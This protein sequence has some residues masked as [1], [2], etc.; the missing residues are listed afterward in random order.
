MTSDKVDFLMSQENGA[1]YIVLYQML[2]LM[3]I[4]TNGELARA[5]NEMLIPYD[6]EKIKRDC[7]YFSTDTIR[8]ALELY[9]KLGMIYV[10]ENGILK[11]ENFSNMVG[12]ETLGAIEKREQRALTN[13][14]I[15]KTIDKRIDNVYQDNKRLDIRDIETRYKRLDN[16]EKKE[17]ELNEEEEK[18]DF[19]REY[20]RSLL[21]EIKNKLPEME[22][23]DYDS[24]FDFLL[25]LSN[26]YTREAIH[27]STLRAL[28]YV[29]N[30]YAN[31][32]NPFGYLRNAIA[33]NW[34]EYGEL[35]RN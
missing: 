22:Q 15:D 35:G 28:M 14:E 33:I 11:I 23:S 3:T 5:I 2:C 21:S 4:N 34:E 10:Q 25:N 32:E 30:N 16:R 8:V 24:L 20:T 19:V 7:K 9:K 27:T 31:I 6:V 17:V 26:T 13:K 18:E 1:N 12:S 29:L